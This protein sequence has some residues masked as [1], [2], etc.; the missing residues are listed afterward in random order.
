MG[1]TEMLQLCAFINT[2]CSLSIGMFNQPADWTALITWLSTNTSY[3]ALVAA[4]HKVYLEAGNE[5]FNS[6]AGGAMYHGDGVLYGSWIGPDMAAAKAATGYNHSGMKLVG[7]GWF[8]PGQCYATFSWAY[9]M[10]TT[11]SLT[12]NGLPDLIDIAPYNF[13]FLSNYTTSGSDVSASASAPWLD[14]F[15]EI[16]N[17]D[18]IIPVGNNVSTLQATSYVKSTFGVDTMVYEYGIGT[19]Q[20]T[21]ITQR[22]LDE[23]TAGVGQ[24]LTLSL[25]SMLMRRD[26]HL[27]GPLGTFALT[28]LYNGFGCLGGGCVG[29]VVFPAWGIERLLPCGPGE[30]STCSDASRPAS[31][32]LQMINNAIGSNSNFMVTTQ[33]GVPTYSYTADQSN[34]GTPTILA[35][36]AVPYVDCGAYSNGSTNWTVLC[37]NKNISSSATVVL[38]GAGAPTGA[39]TKWTY[40]GPGES[41]ISM[42]E[43]TYLGTGSLPPQDVLPSSVST[44]GTSFVIPPASMIALAYTVGAGPIP[45]TPFSLSGTASIGGAASIK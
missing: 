7:N 33:T 32:L 3:L 42:N 30:L 4:G 24:A 20:G 15:A 22:Q 29:G 9:E 28:E 37:W 23:V 10:L 36:S 39:V 27:T 41:L 1:Y 17:Y 18:S 45:T 44:S 5:A 11:A 38:A 8:A 6:G 31:I 2:D 12:A 43:N 26:A 19:I 34:G 14:M 16:S 13:S 21:T 25:H 40:P 35:N